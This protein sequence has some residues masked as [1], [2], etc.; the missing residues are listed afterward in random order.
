MVIPG[1]RSGIVLMTNNRAS[2]KVA[3][4]MESKPAAEDVQS[5]RFEVNDWIKHIAGQHYT[6]R[7]TAEDGYQAE[8]DYSIASPPEQEGILEFGIQ[9]LEDG[10]VS[11]YLYKLPLGEQIEIRGPIGGHFIWE[12]SMPGPLLLIGGGSGMV[13][14]ISILR[15][16]ANHP[17]DREIIFLISVKDQ[18][19]LLY[20]Q[21][22][23]EFPKKFPNIKVIITYTQTPPENW[24][25]F[26]RRVDREMLTEVFSHLL[27]KMPMIYICGRTTLVETVADQL[28]E[29][30]FNPHIIK[31]ERFG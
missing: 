5:L 17:D 2:W 12:S 25:G 4:L 31:T 6:I 10:E 19:R 18:Q 27:E 23:E 16:F 9:I 14:L 13:P 8:R 1:K 7:L 3:T 30:G 20:K 11:P 21:E 22:L 24:D 29:I 15:H 28:V 26:K